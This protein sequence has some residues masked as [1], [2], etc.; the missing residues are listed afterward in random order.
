MCRILYF[1]I[2]QFAEFNLLEWRPSHGPVLKIAKCLGANLATDLLLL[3]P[4]GRLFRTENSL[5][6]C[7][8]VRQR[9]LKYQLLCDKVQWLQTHCG[10]PWI[11]LG[12][13][14]Y[15]AFLFLCPQWSSV[16]YISR[17]F[18]IWTQFMNTSWKKSDLRTHIS[19]TAQANSCRHLSL[20]YYDVFFEKM[21]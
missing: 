7:R 21:K 16:P 20:F 11:S 2:I 4:L 1:L 12:K 3:R 10:Q 5:L 6:H 8:Q 13:S 14:L 18:L 15:K 17:N 9:V 19:S